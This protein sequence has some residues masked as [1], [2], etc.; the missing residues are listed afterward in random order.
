MTTIRDVAVAAGVS[1]QTVSR[2][3]NDSPKVDPGTRRRVLETI[4]RLDYV[5]SAAAQTLSRGKTWAVGV[6]VPWL[7]R[8]SVVARLAGIEAALADT[9]YELVVFS[10]ETPDQ[11]DRRIREILMGGR[12]DGLIVMSLPIHPAER[13]LIAGQPVPAVLLDSYAPTLPRIVCNDVQGGRLA[14]RHLLEL[15]HTRIAFLGDHPRTAW[16]FS[17]SRLRHWGFKH[18]ISA[19]L[20]EDAAKMSALG[21]HSRIA[22][23]ELAIGLL[24][25]KDP[26][27]AIVCAS[28]TQALGTLEAAAQL[29]VSVPGEL[30]V[31]GYD[32]IE[33]AEYLGITTIRQPLQDSGG[34]AAEVLLSLLGGAESGPH[35]RRVLPVELIVRRTSGSPGAG[36]VGHPGQNITAFSATGA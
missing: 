26:P 11:R 34:Q 25:R 30:S 31:T 28:D 32:D 16:G 35:N 19:A 29:G 4:Q 13:R 33:A 9:D 6:V 22:A 5:P 24:R 21:D 18:E 10:I 14:A 8:P 1:R 27:T 20:G 2:V 36:N 12:A 3:L 17:S 15:G 7:A 23:R